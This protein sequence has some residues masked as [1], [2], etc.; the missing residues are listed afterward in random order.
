MDEDDVLSSTSEELAGGPTDM[1]PPSG[2]EAHPSLVYTEL[3]DVISL[4][5]K[6]P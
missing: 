2:Q 6:Q 3:F 4:K 5:V 1:P